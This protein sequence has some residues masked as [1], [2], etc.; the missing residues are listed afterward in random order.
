[1]VKVFP[2]P[3]HLCLLQREHILLLRDPFFETVE[4]YVLKEHDW[5]LAPD[6]GFMSHSAF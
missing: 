2:S 5:V 3:N 6:G 4:Q 1:M